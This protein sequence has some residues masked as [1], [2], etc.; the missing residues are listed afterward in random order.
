MI[1]SSV[2]CLARQGYSFVGTFRIGCKVSGERE[3]PT[4]LNGIGGVFVWLRYQ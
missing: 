3:R 4:T 1:S 2:H